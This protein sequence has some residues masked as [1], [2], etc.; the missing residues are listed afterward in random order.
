[1]KFISCCHR[2]INNGVYRTGFTTSQE[3][4]DKAVHEVFAALDR[5]CG[6]VNVWTF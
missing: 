5:V 4:Y 3:V 2:D 1:M 6:L